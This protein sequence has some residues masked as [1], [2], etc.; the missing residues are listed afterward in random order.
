MVTRFNSDDSGGEPRVP[1]LRTGSLDSDPGSPSSPLSPRLALPDFSQFALKPNQTIRFTVG[2]LGDQGSLI[3]TC[4][5]ED[6]GEPLKVEITRPDTR[7]GYTISITPTQSGSHILH[8]TIGG[9][10]DLAMGDQRNFVTGD[11]KHA[12]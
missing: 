9:K 5:H 10:R 2:T 11:Q 12:A 4:V 6:S 8:F 7:P 1:L 3:C